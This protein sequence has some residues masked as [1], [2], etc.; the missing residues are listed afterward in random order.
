M[1]RNST[2]TAGKDRLAAQLFIAI[3]LVAV[4]AMIRY[5]QTRSGEPNGSTP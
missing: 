1:A 5:A 3:P 4:L 2:S